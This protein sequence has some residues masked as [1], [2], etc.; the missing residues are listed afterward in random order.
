[1]PPKVKRRRR[2]AEQMLGDADS[3]QSRYWCEKGKPLD[4]GAVLDRDAMV[5]R[6]EKDADFAH[7]KTML[8]EFYETQPHI[9]YILCAKFWCDLQW[10]EQ[11]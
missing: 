2:S 10:V 1:M 9:A 8:E 3:F 4:G 11:Y 5:A 6:L 7:V